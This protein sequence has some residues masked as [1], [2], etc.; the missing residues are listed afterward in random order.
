MGHFGR[1]TSV[2]DLPPDAVILGLVRQAVA[3]NDAGI[4]KP[5]PKKRTKNDLVVP[6]WFLKALSKKGRAVFDAFS[7][8]HK[9]EYVKWV[10]EAKQEETRA[11]RL[12]TTIEWLEQGKTR[13]WKYQ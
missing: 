8:S 7:P 11:R 9:R 4:K 3:L 5:A 6:R 10:T 2:A 13:N 1:V 12:A